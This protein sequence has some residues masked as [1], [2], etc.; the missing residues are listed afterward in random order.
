MMSVISTK[1]IPGNK[2]LGVKLLEIGTT[3]PESAIEDMEV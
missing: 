1:R 2:Q 3:D